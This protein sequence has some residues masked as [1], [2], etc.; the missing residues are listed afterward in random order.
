MTAVGAGELTG[1]G[2]A[3]AG[4]CSCMV[5]GV[6]WGWVGG[7]G[8]ALQQPCRL[9]GGPVGG[10]GMACQL[11]WRLLLLMLLQR[12]LHPTRR[13]DPLRQWLA[14]LQVGAS[15]QIALEGGACS[16]VLVVGWMTTNSQIPAHHGIVWAILQA[17][18]HIGWG[19]AAMEGA[20]AGVG[21]DLGPDCRAHLWVGLAWA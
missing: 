17:H 14:P 2:A 6:G 7:T 13:V 21:L 4:G 20:L 12:G 18:V 16:K 9:V 19:R 10:A 5:E 1:R 11:T 15:R 3:L 8:N